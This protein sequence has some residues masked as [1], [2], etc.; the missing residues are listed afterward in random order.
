VTERKRNRGW[1]WYFAILVV[2]TVVAITI[3]FVYNQGQQLRPEKLEAAR[4]LWEEKRPADYVL[5]YTK[6]GDASGTFVVTVRQG[7]VVSVIMRE[8]VKKENEVQVVEQPLEQRLY[9]TYDME[10]LFDNIERF[11]EL[12]AKKDS[13]RVYLFARF[14]PKNGQLLKFARRV[15]GT[16]QHVEIDVEPIQAPAAPEPAAPARAKST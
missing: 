8:E 9:H 14:D 13:P 2:L 15:M 16:A 7:K 5:T 1:I 10:G 11:L 12:A 6:K 4:K 3:L